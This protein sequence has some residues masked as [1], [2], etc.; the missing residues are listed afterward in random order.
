MPPISSEFYEQG[1]ALYQSGGGLLQ[2][3]AQAD[4]IQANEEREHAAVD[5]VPPA[6]IAAGSLNEA[7]D[8]IRQR[9]RFAEQSLTLGFAEGVLA[10]IRSIAQRGRGQRA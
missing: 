1:R 2:M 7:H 4:G 9:Y 3:T 5:A 6:G 10:D 8:A